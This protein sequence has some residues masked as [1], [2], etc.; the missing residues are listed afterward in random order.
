MVSVMNGKRMG[1]GF[2]M[3]PDSQSDDGLFDLCIVEN[4]SKGRVLGLIPYFLKGTQATQPEVKMRRSRTVAIRSLD[5]TFPA[6]ADGEFI[7]LTGSHLT[8]ELLPRAIEIICA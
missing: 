5:K 2:R 4:P 1:G 6:H 7:C 8:L 3:T